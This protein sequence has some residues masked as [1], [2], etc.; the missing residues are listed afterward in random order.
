MVVGGRIFEARF[1]KAF[2]AQHAVVTASAMEK[3]VFR[4]FIHWI[5]ATHG[6]GII[7]AEAGPAGN[8]TGLGQI[9]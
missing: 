2:F 9:D 5:V 3:S 7:D 4:R 1:G 6:P 8:D